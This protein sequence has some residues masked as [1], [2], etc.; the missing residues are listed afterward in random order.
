MVSKLIGNTYSNLI[1]F[2]FDMSSRGF[3][4]VICKY[5]F[6]FRVLYCVRDNNPW[7][8]NVHCKSKLT[9]NKL[10]YSY[11]ILILMYVSLRRFILS[12]EIAIDI[13]WS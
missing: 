3:V 11:Y 9:I 6:N 5:G 12:I 7:L 8:A 2:G 4:S 1:I 10:S 13:Y